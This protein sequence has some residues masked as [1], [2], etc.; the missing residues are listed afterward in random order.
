MTKQEKMHTIELSESELAAILFL[1]NKSNGKSTYQL[2]KRCKDILTKFIDEDDFE[3]KHKSL[4][5]ECGYCDYI[6]YYSVEKE[7]E[8]FLGVS[9]VDIK[10]VRNPLTLENGSAIIAEPHT[11][12]I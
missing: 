8:D 7:W 2:W 6:D 5:E 12:E 10:M 1:L 11:I 3:N 4:S 9:G